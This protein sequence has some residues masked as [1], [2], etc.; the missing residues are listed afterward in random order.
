MTLDELQAILKASKW[1]LLGTG[2]YNKVYLSADPLTIEGYTSRWVLKIQ[3]EHQDEDMSTSERALRKWALLNPEFPAWRTHQGW[4]SPYLG[5]VAA[6]DEQVATKLIDIYRR[7]R[8]IIADACKVR[9][10]L[11]HEGRVICVDVDLALRRGSR[12]TERFL[13]GATKNLCGHWEYWAIHGMPKTTVVLRTLF[14]VQQHC[15]DHVIKDDYISASMFSKVRLFQQR[16]LALTVQILDILFEITAQNVDL[17]LSDE[18]I[19][20]FCNHQIIFSPGVN[21]SFHCV[22]WA[23]KYG[24]FQ[25]LSLLLNREPTLLDLKDE[26]NQTP[27]IWACTRGHLQVVHLLISKGANLEAS[28]QLDVLDSRYELEH[29]RTA[30]DWAIQGGYAPIVDCLRYHGSLA[31]KER[32]VRPSLKSFFDSVTRA[33]ILEE[34]GDYMSVPLPDS[35]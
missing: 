10:F 35:P 29:G 4:I 26:H 31:R 33:K 14:Y 34:L 27:L 32:T 20:Y 7:T 8:Q 13:S 1:N 16:H 3:R 18:Q 30:L 24:L 9:N 17:L 5:D 11:F 19:L 28:T 23:A 6:S 12:L 15:S 2:T 25:L 21:G 22:H